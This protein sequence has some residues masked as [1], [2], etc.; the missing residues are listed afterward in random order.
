MN[1]NFYDS[2]CVVFL[3]INILHRL[4]YYATGNQETVFYTCFNTNDILIHEY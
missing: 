1:H 2:A 4:V 3:A